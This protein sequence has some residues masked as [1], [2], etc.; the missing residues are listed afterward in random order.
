MLVKSEN[1]EGPIGLLLDLI[2]KKK[3][4]I[5]DI[6]LAEISNQFLERVKSFENFPRAEVARF[7]ETA[8]I[9]ML[10]KSRALLPQ[11]EIDDEEKQSIDEL[12]RRL[13]IY[14]IIRETSDAIKKI[15]GKTPM[16]QRES[17]VNAGVIFIKP[18]NLSLENIV[19]T[20]KNIIKYLPKEESFPEAKIGKIIKLEEKIFALA[21]RMQ[22]N[23]QTCF[24]DFAR[25]GDRGKILT[26]EELA[27]I[28]TEIIVSFLA[29]LEL[30]KQGMAIAVQEN[31]F[32][33]ISIQKSESLS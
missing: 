31:P 30:I 24:Y 22:K 17:C 5:N 16:F 15:Y 29:L 32:G 10:I 8:S 25:T 1:F 33:D 7:I 2:E 19:E 14:K 3:M 21:E 6:S 11:M 4:P 20:A 26:K 23:I 27:E 12:E 9:L 18:A 13:A 28:K